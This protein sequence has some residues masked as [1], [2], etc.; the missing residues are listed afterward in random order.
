MPHHRLALV[1]QAFK[2]LDITGDGIVTIED[3]K[4]IYNTE[5]LDDPHL[6]SFEWKG[7]AGLNS[8][9]KYFTRP[10]GKNKVYLSKLSWR[11]NLFY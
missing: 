8:L 10:V 4:M 5:D 1:D 9:V 7:A 2:K 11:G 3:I 6:N